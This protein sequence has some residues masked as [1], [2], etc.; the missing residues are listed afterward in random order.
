MTWAIRPLLLRHALATP[1]ARSSHRVPTPQGAGIAVDC[2]HAADRR[3][4]DCLGRQ[5]RAVYPGRGFGRI[6]VHRSGRLR[7]RRQIH[8]GTAATAA[9]GLGGRRDPVFGARRS[10]DRFRLSALDRTRPAVDCGP[11]VRES[12]QLHG[13]TGLDD[14]GRGRP[15]HRRDGCASAR[16]A[17]F[18]CRQPSLPRRCA[19][20]CWDLLRSTVQS[21]KSFSATSA[22][23]RSV[24]C[25][26]GVC[27]NWPITS[28]SP[29]HCCCHCIICWMPRRPCCA[30]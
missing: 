2:G 1:N 4:R 21:R 8:P 7:G 23:C 27:C 16:L 28:N 10:P 14:G 9:T 12:G 3:G 24:C 17:S 22:A 30:G 29:Q 6:A 15:D 11:L 5:D 18:R 20:R 13:W 19:A 26:A 25:S